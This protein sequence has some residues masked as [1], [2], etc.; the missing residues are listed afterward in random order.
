MP[1]RHQEEPFYLSDD[2]RL[3]WL[4]LDFLCYVEDIQ[5]QGDTSKQR[6]TKETYEATISTTRSTVALIEYLLD[7]I[8]FRY[9]LK[10]ALNSDPVESLFSS[11]RQF[12]GGNDRVD[13]RAAVFT[14]E[15]ILKVGIL[16]ASKSAN[17]PINSEATTAVKLGIHDCE[18]RTLPAAITSAA[19][20]LSNE[21]GFIHVWCEPAA[22]IELAPIT[23]VAG[24]L[25]RAC[26]QKVS[27][28]S[29]RTPLQVAKPIEEIYGLIKNLDDGRLRYLKIEIVALCKL[30]CTFV[31]NVIKC[32]EVRRSSKLCNM[33]VSTLLHY[34]EQSTA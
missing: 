1:W 25:A 17:A 30:T 15:K 20:E 27:C 23:Y 13:A 12:N 21:L 32:P 24:Y 28:D 14:S 2:E 6:L 8:N 34:F 29:C 33:L 19:R 10:Q 18:S 7:H 5:A 11:L 3:S 16:Q 26:E 31:S 9:V 4:E 22:D